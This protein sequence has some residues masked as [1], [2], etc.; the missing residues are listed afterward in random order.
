METRYAVLFKETDKAHDLNM[1]CQALLSQKRCNKICCHFIIF[2]E[3][4]AIFN[5]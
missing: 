1:K 2:P 3:R 5:Y 4:K